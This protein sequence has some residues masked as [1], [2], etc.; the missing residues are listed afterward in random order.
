M[1]FD[2]VPFDVFEE[3]PDLNKEAWDQIFKEGS[4]AG[5]GSEITASSANYYLGRIKKNKEKLSQYTE[6][7][8]QMKDDFKVRVEAWL[9]SR[10][11]ALDYDTQH[12]MDMLEM[13]YEKNKTADG[14]SISLPEGN[15]GMY[16][17]RAKYDFDTAKEEILKFLQEHPELQQFIR[18]KPEINKSIL[19][20]A[21]VVA[22]GKLYVDGY[23][24]PHAGYTPKTTEF[25][26]R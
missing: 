3:D 26:I 7:A 18:N 10:Q 17:V 25:G 2:D 23:E 11:K 16:S 1:G 9:Q 21:C 8:K 22:D 15:I 6:Q 24:I 13:Y 12:C 5:E 20:K 19:Q 14:K 4:E